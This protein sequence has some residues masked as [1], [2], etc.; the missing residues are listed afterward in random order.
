[1]QKKVTIAPKS[2]AKEKEKD[3]NTNGKSQK[4]KADPTKSLLEKSKV[5]L[6]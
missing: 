4:D 3:K 6:S 1:M 5:M 2:P